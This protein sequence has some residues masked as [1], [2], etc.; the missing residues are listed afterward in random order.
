M[1]DKIFFSYYIPALERAFEE[2]N[3]NYGFLVKQPS[4]FY[5]DSLRFDLEVYEDSH[6]LEYPI[7]EKVAYYFDA[8]SHGFDMID[9]TSIDDY[10]KNLMLEM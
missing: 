10:K 8:K 2:D 5:P 4:W 1:N 7:L 3:V 6:Y 9:N